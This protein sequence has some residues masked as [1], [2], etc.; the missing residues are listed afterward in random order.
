MRSSLP[1]W[2]T[3]A[4]EMLSAKNFPSRICFLKV[5][6]GAAVAAVAHASAIAGATVAKRERES[7]AEI[8]RGWGVG[9]TQPAPEVK[10]ARVRRAILDEERRKR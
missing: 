4:A 3:S 10:R 6:V 8:M 5:I 9:Q 2:L 7:E 1:A